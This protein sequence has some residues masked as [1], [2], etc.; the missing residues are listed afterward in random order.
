MKDSSKNNLKIHS[1][2][3]ETTF[4]RYRYGQ[5]SENQLSTT[6]NSHSLLFR[7]T[8]NEETK[9]H[10]NCEIQPARER[11]TIPLSIEKFKHLAT[12]NSSKFYRFNDNHYSPN[13]AS[14][15]RI[16]NRALRI[17]IPYS[18]FPIIATGNLR[19]VNLG[20]FSISRGRGIDP[21]RIQRTTLDRVV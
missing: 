5:S 4:W 15:F 18:Q 19:D 20:E 13:S 21:R 17:S 11:A 2:S 14:P 9:I 10:P 3:I 7:H 12:L 8:V 6:L 16:K 1:R